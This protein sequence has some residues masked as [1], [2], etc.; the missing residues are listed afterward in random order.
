MNR[1][2]SQSSLVQVANDSVRTVFGTAENNRPRRR[3]AL[4]Q[5]N[6]NSCLLFL[7]DNTHRLLNQFRGLLL[8]FNRDADR[9]V[10]HRIRQL[11]NLR[12]HR[13]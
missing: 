10:Q 8:R 6:Q 7:R 3:H 13:G 9:I 1:L 5:F 11:P 12:L 4:D 2:R